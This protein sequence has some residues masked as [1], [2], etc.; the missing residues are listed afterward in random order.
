ML[1]AS[2]EIVEAVG[3]VRARRAARRRASWPTWCSPQ[4]GEPRPAGG[5]R[6]DASCPA[7]CSRA[8]SRSRA[9]LRAHAERQARPGDIAA[10]QPVIAPE[11]EALLEPLERFEAIRRRAARL[12]D[13]LCDLSYANPYD[14]RRDDGAGGAAPRRSTTSARSTCS[15]RRSAAR[16]W[17]AAR[18]PTRCARATTCR[19]RFD[20]VVLTPGRDVG[21]APRAARGGPAGRRGGGPGALLARLSALRARPRA[22]CRVLVPLTPRT[23]RPRRRARWPARSRT[24]PARCCSATRRTRPAAATARTRW[25]RSPTSL[26]R[27]EA[28]RSVPDHPDRRRD[29]PRLRRAR[30]VPQRGP[31]FDRTSIVYSFGKYH[32]M[33]GQRLGYV[34]V[35]PRHPAREAWPRELVRWTRITGIATPTALMQ[36]AL[37]RAAGAA[38]RPRLARALAASGCCDELVARRLRGGRAR[39]DDVRLRRA[40]RPARRRLRVRRS[41]SRAKGVL[42]LPAPVFHHQGYFRLSLTGSE[43]MLDAG[44]AG[45]RGNGGRD[46]R[47]ARGR[48]ARPQLRLG[49]RAAVRDDD[50][51]P[52]RAPPSGCAARRRRCVGPERP[53]WRIVR[54]PLGIN[55]LFWARGG[56]RR[57]PSR[58]GPRRLIE[59]GHAWTRSRAIPRG[60]MRRPRSGDGTPTARDRA[61]RPGARA[62]R[63]GEVGRRRRAARSRRALDGYL[64]ALASAHPRARAFV[65]LSGGL[66][67]SGIAALAREHFPGCD[68]GQLRPGARPGGAE[69]GPPRRRAARARP[70][71]AAARGDRHRGRAARARSTPCCVEGVDWRDFNVHAALVNAALAAGD[72]RAAGAGRARPARAHRRPGE[73]VPGRLRGRAL[74]R[75]RPTTGCRGSRRRRCAR[76]SCAAWTRSHREIGVFGAWGL[77]VVQPYAAA[78]R[79]L[80]GPARRLPRPTR[81]QGAPVP[82]AAS[83]QR[84]P[85]YVYARRKARAQVGGADAAAACSRPASTAGIDAAWLRRRFAALH[86]VDRPGRARPLHPRRRYRSAVPSLTG[87]R[88]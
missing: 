87:D 69:R 47:R 30:A 41:S 27:A 38:A 53:T 31:F 2:G 56:R 18:W 17:S 71:H 84:V 83:A 59:A 76:A 77:P 40:P 33:Q 58:R 20:D 29:A 43:D 36:R 8:G 23:L 4:D 3:D 9:T 80:P 42:A 46:E 44:A 68:G 70:R 19:S 32:F 66:D 14:G 26:R 72:R 16:R 15:T 45:P 61:R 75:R 52:D 6:R 37:P 74:P 63:A 55:K 86:G 60:A 39:R 21:A 25:R 28:R 73:R 5:V 49:R 22:R 13:R 1:Y 79:R 57:S 12:G 7:T 64:A 82:R 65:C 34:A 24:G 50:L 48:R 62:E 51:T 11:L 78:V 10:A 54:D 85:E 35:S 88:A 67:S 81:L